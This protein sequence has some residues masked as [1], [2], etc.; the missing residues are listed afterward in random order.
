MLIQVDS[1]VCPI[2]CDVMDDPVVACDGYSYDRSAIESWLENHSTSPV[3]NNQLATKDLLPNHSLR[4]AILE[5]AQP[6]H[7]PLPATPNAATNR[8]KKTKKPATRKYVAPRD[9]SSNNTA[10]NTPRQSRRLQ[11]LAPDGPPSK[12]TRQLPPQHGPRRPSV[13]A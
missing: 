10:A 12:R 4:Q 8:T 1:F 6:R 2:T 9:A 13:E 5:V 7:A 3:T 11:R